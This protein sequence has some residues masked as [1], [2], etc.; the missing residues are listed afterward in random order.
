MQSHLATAGSVSRRSHRLDAALCER[1][2][3]AHPLPVAD[4][5]AA[6]LA[7]DSAFEER[8]RV[9]EVF[10]ASLRLLAAV[11]LAARLQLGPGPAGESPQVPELLRTLR[12][13]GLTDG[14]WMALVR[15]ALR[16]W[17]GAAEGFPVPEL[18]SLVHARKA[19][20]PKLLDELLVMRK[21]ETVAHGATGTRAAIDG[22]LDKRLPQL[23]RMLELLDTVWARAR[24][25]VPLASRGDGE[26]P[27]AGWLLVGTTPHRGRFR[28]VELA[29]A[30][31]LPPGEAL[32]VDRDG[33]PLI[34]LHP[35]ALF[36]RPSPE[37]VE[38]LFLLDGGS[39]RGAVYVAFPSMSEHRE[40][41]AWRMIEGVLSEDAASPPGG[42][43]SR[44][45][46]GAPAGRPYRGLAS[47]GLEDA[48]LFFGR[49]EQAEALANRI[50]RHGMVTVTGPSGSGKSSLLRAG[51]LP[52]LRDATTTFV[53]PGVDPL[54]SLATKLAESL[55]VDRSELCELGRGD[56]AELAARVDRTARDGG[57]IHVVIVDQGEELL[58][59]TS[60]P[61]ARE[62][63]ARA[64]VSLASSD[65]ATR[66]VLGVRED[67]FGRLATISSLRDI[68]SRQVEVVTTP[69]RPALIRT[70]V[71]PA[72]A[73]G[74]V[75]E[76][77]E[78]VTTMVD[79]VA[80]T[81]AALAL[82]QF[83]ADRLWEQRDRKWK[84]LTWDAYRS[85]GGVAGALAQHA[86][87]VLA[88]LSA[89]ERSACRV[90]FL[91]LVSGERT[92]A[93]VPKP[94]LLDGL[95]H[96][97]T[98]ERVLD[99]LIAARLVSVTDG[100]SGEATLEIVHEALLRH[101]AALDRW[102]GE[103]EE[104]Q[105]LAHAMR[106]AARDWHG[107]GRPRDL[108]W[109]GDL[110]D[111]LRRY[112][113]RTSDA[114]A[115]IEAAFADASEAE[116]RRGRRIRVG[117]VAGALT[118]LSGFSVFAAWQWRRSEAA[119]VE[120][121]KQRL[122]T[123][124]EKTNA[125]IRGLVAEAR[126]HEPAGRTGHALVLLRAAS[127]LE[128][129]QGETGSSLLSLE[130]ERL[131]RSGAGGRVLA[132]HSFGVYRVC[133]PPDTDRVVTTSLDETTRIWEL[134]T[135]RVLHTIASQGMPVRG[136]ACSPDGKLF[137]TG[138]SD[139]KSVEGRLSLW[140]VAT[141]ARTRSFEGI[142]SA[143][144]TV[145]FV[146]GGSRLITFAQDAVLRVFDVASGALAAS[147]EDP[148]DR[149]LD[150]DAT[151]DGK[152]VATTSGERVELW[153]PGVAQ[154]LRTMQ[155]AAKVVTVALSDDGARL[156]WAA[157]E[158]GVVSLVDAT[159]GETVKELKPAGTL[160][161][162]HV[163][164]APGGHTLV[165][166]GPRGVDLWDAGSGAR[167]GHLRVD[168]QHTE[169]EFS[170]QGDRLVTLREQS[171][172]ELWDMATGARLAGLTG[173][174]A[175]IDA[176]AFSRDGR[177]LV[178]G[179]FD[180]TARIYDASRTSLVHFWTSGAELLRGWTV[181]RDGTRIAT[182]GHDGVVR[183]FPADGQGLTPPAGVT[184]G[185]AGARH[186]AFSPDGHVLLVG[187][188]AP[189][190]R[191]I[192]AASG[193]V[194]HELPLDAPLSS[195]GWSPDGGVVAIGAKDGALHLFGPDG[196]PAK[197]VRA[198]TS[199]VTTIALSPRG[200]LAAVGYQDRKLRIVRTATGEVVREP[201]D[202]VGPASAI[203]FAPDG[204]S[205]AVADQERVR[206]FETSSWAVQ[207]LRDHEQAVIAV[208]FSP[209]GKTL[210]SASADQT[211][212]LRTRVGL[213]KKLTGHTAAVLDVAFA[214]DG[215]RIVSAGEDGSARVWDLALGTALEII[216]PFGGAVEGARFTSNDRIAAIGRGAN[217]GAA[218]VV[219][220]SPPDRTASV[221]AAG[222]V[223]NLRVCRASY[224]V[225]A[226]VPPPSS[227][228]VWAP[229]ESCQASR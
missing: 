60:E 182:I 148:K 71:A 219:A 80:E 119:R 194:M 134:S 15:E 9:V 30:Q 40:A 105:R 77:E 180:R 216:E 199:A 81:P 94:E 211:I 12:S 141:G 140:D 83:C 28:N 22:I 218:A 160:G 132:G 67:F 158:G 17:A 33:R 172:A 46:P 174:D 19:E 62:R 142:P 74:Y 85:V 147:I 86:D 170:P 110:L 29:S 97:E 131:A 168:P 176:I 146:A 129:E 128:E 184:L 137:A 135:G 98:G 208:A 120:T 177:T 207:E 88:S 90:L 104:G 38:E 195:L 125:E 221:L 68:Y 44:S 47:F 61:D 143:I 165:T 226:L 58:T 100:A 183:L 178:T 7:A 52:L 49:E 204:G 190:A 8:D 205:L 122:A 59:L 48:A 55:G 92:R 150:F 99:A 224:A 130:L 91:R 156:A 107:R 1:V 18:V 215:R 101:W 111:E 25:C 167:A 65:G 171:S 73:F 169:F 6:L 222:A 217:G 186:V 10:R 106:Q 121:E 45:E 189:V 136:L 36:R 82:L 149:L 56:P 113:Q 187:A 35:V 181:S 87:K 192:D 126:G 228:S 155:P 213:D 13:R 185:G 200:D 138:T 79:A 225:V 124:H 175:E 114:L 4:A 212:A 93:V 95:R 202:T 78:L 127:R 161:V 51:V 5:L 24:L 112:R 103:D 69:D 220:S 197:T 89:A 151:S 201:P 193:A 188:D 223:T 76:D 164:F 31:P 196:T 21:S 214:P 11:A 227:E 116:L 34:A 210:A 96:A 166:S 206:W 54:G 152:L 162:A 139:V 41:D 16:P 209:D 39:K 14:Q 117:V 37:A 145:E 203:E 102:L 32:L 154:P 108:L 23:G 118:I 144:T 43:P 3:A 198:G 42:A 133:L 57:T 75:F 20:L 123:A 70:L 173:H 2:L 26:G 64:L 84:R 109:R 63:F 163:G 72:Q 191:M 179:S 159:T 53:R 27:P 153:V 229:D 50:R 115:G 66:V 157:L